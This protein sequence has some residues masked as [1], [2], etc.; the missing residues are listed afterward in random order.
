MDGARTADLRGRAVAAATVAILVALLAGGVASLRGG[1]RSELES[2]LKRTKGDRIGMRL[3]A[4]QAGY[5][6]EARVD[7]RVERA[8]LASRSDRLVFLNFW[9]TFCPPCIEELP[10][11]L[12]LARS[13]ADE[14]VTV[15]AV[16]YDESWQQID[17]FFR[18]FTSDSIPP[19]FVVVRDPETVSGRDMKSLFG[20]EK[21]PESY[22]IRDGA[23][24]VKFVSARDWAGPEMVA[25]FN[26]LLGR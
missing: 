23:I 14:G 24:D 16:S 6:F 8:S 17:D 10:S 21:L 11:L 9:G 13:R 20:T 3:N 1:G 25:L 18:K 22:V 19:N 5:P 15:V 12:A 4:G 7:G 26:V 2:L